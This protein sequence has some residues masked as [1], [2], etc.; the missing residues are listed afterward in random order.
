MITLYELDRME[1]CYEA[2]R[3][4]VAELTRLGVPDPESE[5]R[6][7]AGLVFGR[8][9]EAVAE[10]QSGLAS[11]REHGFSRTIGAA[12]SVL[13]LIL[14]HRDE[15]DEARALLDEADADLVARGG[16]GGLDLLMLS[17][18]R[19]VLLEATGDCQ[20]AFQIYDGAFSVLRVGQC[21]PPYREIAPDLARV[22]VAVG[23]A[24]VARQA[25]A[26]LEAVAALEPAVASLQ[27]TALRT[28]AMAEQD[29]DLMIQAVITYRS[30][31]RPPEHAYAA[32]EAGLLLAAAGRRDEAIAC[33]QEA[34]EIYERLDAARLV[35]RADAALRSLGV[36]RGRAGARRRPKTGWESL[37]ET[38]Q[39]VV[40]LIAEGLANGRIAERLYISKRTVE[41]HA[42]SIMRKLGVSSRA[43]LIAQAARR[44]RL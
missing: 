21:V 39:R 11:H 10:A 35:A 42:S 44:Q 12:I 30:S 19:A 31:P 8:W 36:K 38:E 29:P 17:W 22:A 33:L 32:E 6:G 24:D 4:L 1:E 34:V 14:M 15:L 28:R 27:G 5:M 20:S 16:G 18:A 23:R 13:A 9:D 2:R 41:T 40:T 3:E 37:T 26:E 43:E 25:A 7:T